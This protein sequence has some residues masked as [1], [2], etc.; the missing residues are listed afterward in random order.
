[1]GIKEEVNVEKRS[2][3]VK[4]M[5]RTKGVLITV[6]VVSPT[7]RS[8]HTS[9]PIKRIKPN[10]FSLKPRSV[11]TRGYDRRAQLLA[12]AQ[13]LRHANSQPSPQCPKA[14]SLPKLKKWRWSSCSARRRLSFSP[15]FRRRK[16]AWRY[17]RIISDEPSKVDRSCGTKRFRSKSRRF[18]RRLGCMLKEISCG[19]HCN[20]V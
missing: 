19:W 18:W 8:H 11:R 16:R 12:Y 14:K 4:E 6:Y 5:A 1:M 3:N 20:K 9:D 7:I 2:K 15:L 10:P 17:Q 13:E